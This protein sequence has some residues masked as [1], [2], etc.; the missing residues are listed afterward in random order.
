VADDI[1]KRLA[2]HLDNLPGGF[3]PT[4]SGV[5]IRILKRLFTP[6]EVEFALQ[7]TLIPEEARVIAHRAKVTIRDA[8]V[9]LESMA[10]RGLV[11]RVELKIGQPMYMAAQ[12]VIGIWEFHV[13]ALDQAF[14]RDMEE[15]SPTLLPEA[16]KI[17]QLR[18]LP[19]NK[20]LNNQLKVMTYE[21]AEELVRNVK[22]AVVAPCICRRERRI[23]GEGCDKP[24][25]VCISFGIAADFYQSNGLGRV[26]DHQEVLKLL[27][28]A[29][30]AGMILQPT[31]AK[32]I[33]SICICCG[34]CCGVLRYIKNYPKP[35][36]LVSTVFLAV[37]NS[38]ACEGCGICEARCQMEAVQL[39]GDKASIDV[40]RCIGCGLC[41][42]TCPTGSLTLAR[43]PDSDQPDVPKDMLRTIIEMG[44]ARGKLGIGD[45]VMMQV[46]SK[47]DR[48]L[49]SKK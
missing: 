20:S 29:D 21:N 31:N 6:E 19:V 39:K 41:I 47:V 34:C 42:S 46:K 16:W 25:E 15:Y 22:K 9:R 18:T 14:I 43:K 40:N 17:P 5:E 28:R 7:L 36:S 3:P 10:K 13:N 4:E 27:K 11:F 49:A 23:M 48:L 26:I 2:E 35:A 37:A 45:L 32:D 24:E 38:D 12:F 1:Y 44:R 30:E 33:L 8:E